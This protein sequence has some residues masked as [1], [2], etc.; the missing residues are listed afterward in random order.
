[1]HKFTL[2]RVVSRC[3]LSICGRMPMIKR[4]ARSLLALTESDWFAFQSCCS[5]RHS[6]IVA[7]QLHDVP[8]ARQF[9]H[10]HTTTKCLGKPDKCKRVLRNS[11]K[12]LRARPS[13]TILCW[14]CVPCSIE[15][16]YIYARVVLNKSRRAGF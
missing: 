4:Y 8:L 11:R 16:E 10:V 9:K 3:S 13:R 15:S 14:S 7:K 5:R 6:F 1:M 2:E 12:F